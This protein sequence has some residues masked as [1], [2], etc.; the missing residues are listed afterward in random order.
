MIATSAVGGTLREL[1]DWG[2]AQKLPR[3]EAE[4]L[5]A[6]ALNWSRTQLHTWPETRPGAEAYQR[7]RHWVERRAAG[8]PIAYLTGTREFWSLEL[9][10]TPDTLIPRPDT[11]LLVELALARI[12]AGADWEIA[13]LGTGSGAVALA[14]A[15]ERSRCRITATDLSASALA[16]AAAN[17]QRHLLDNVRFLQGDWW[18]PL[19]GR[20]FHGVVSNPPYVTSSDPHLEQGDLIH[21]PRAAL[22]AGPK[23]L[24]ALRAIAAGCRDHLHPHG[25]LLLEHGYNQGEEVRALLR[26][27]GLGDVETHRDLAGQERVTA[28]RGPA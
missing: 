3:L 8:E 11:E 7:Y 20:H 21:E 6:R 15:K 25:W 16:V 27:A 4:L 19:Q 26:D 1:I 14:L 5:L 12:P 13:D 10:V 28:G 22:A 17:A 18:T 9:S 23:G 24:D 2:M